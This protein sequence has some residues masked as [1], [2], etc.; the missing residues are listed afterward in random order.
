MV[1]KCTRHSGRAFWSN[2]IGINAFDF[3]CPDENQRF[4][5]CKLN[6]ILLSMIPGP[7][8]QYI[9]QIK[10]VGKVLGGLSFL[11]FLQL[12]LQFVSYPYWFVP[13]VHLAASIWFLN[14]F[15]DSRGF[16][17]RTYEH[18]SNIQ[19]SQK[20][21]VTKI[22]NLKLLKSQHN[23]F[24]YKWFH[25]N[26]QQI[27]TSIIMWYHRKS[28]KPDGRHPQIES[29]IITNRANRGSLM[30]LVQYSSCFDLLIK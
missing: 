3:Q 28:H 20:D 29:N 1:V 15:L 25:S 10:V 12:W 30:R 27:S 21:F 5:T 7:W 2:N 26:P 14:Y 11:S 16:T 9:F 19:K 24:W 4:S 18:D 17:A 6:I 22:Q 8:T 23:Q 13:D